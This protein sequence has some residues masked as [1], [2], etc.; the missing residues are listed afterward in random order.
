MKS[1]E[2]DYYIYIDYS[3]NLIG[4]NII[5]KNKIKCLL[6]KITKFRHYR[7]AK[8]RKLYIKYI[9]QTI[10]REKILD[11]LIKIKIRNINKNIE[12]FA[13]VFEFLKCH[14]NCIVFISIDDKQYSSFERFVD[15]I[16]RNNIEV[17][18]ESEL[19]INSSEYKLS[20]L[21]DNLL[22]IER[23]KHKRNS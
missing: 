11:D 8:N 9:N 19:K 13:D 12:I 1:K 18:K 20:L 6:S 3:E 5:E 7:N 14:D 4:Y 21:L 15:I 16:D 10:Y 23:L 2:F 17:K 22:N